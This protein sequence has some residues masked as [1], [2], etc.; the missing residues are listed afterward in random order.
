MYGYTQEID[1]DKM[2]KAYTECG[3]TFET[4]KNVEKTFK[5]CIM[6]TKCWKPVQN[7]TNVGN[8][9]SGNDVAGVEACAQLETF[10]RPVRHNKPSN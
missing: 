1:V 3:K 9:N 8:L 7:E 5:T 2:F 10:V 4:C 6:W